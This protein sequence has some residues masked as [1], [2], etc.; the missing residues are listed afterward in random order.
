MREAPQSTSCRSDNARV[1]ARPGFS[2]RGRAAGAQRGARLRRRRVVTRSPDRG[3]TVC[4]MANDPTAGRVLGTRTVEK[5]VRI[6]ETAERL[7]VPI[8]Y[9]VI[10][11]GPDHRPVRFPDG[12]TRGASSTRRSNS[13]VV[14]Q[15][16]LLFGPSAAGGATSPLL[17]H[18]D[19]G[20]GQRQHVLGSPRWRDGDR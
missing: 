5:I 2:G 12:G 17:R 1:A 15:I 6:Q 14:P 10:R 3:R 11:G 7:R 20:R 16:C 8:F 19:H 4:V 18:H 9:L 13:P